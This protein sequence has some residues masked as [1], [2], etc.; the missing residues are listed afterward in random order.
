MKSLGAKDPCWCGSE[1]AFRDCHKLQPAHEANTINA[2]AGV[3]RKMQRWKKCYHWGAPQECARKIIRAHTIQRK[4][5]LRHIL[6]SSQHCLTF[7]EPNNDQS[8]L[9]IPK[10]VGWRNATAFFGFCEDHDRLFSEIEDGNFNVCSRNLLLAAYR[11]VSFEFHQKDALIDAFEHF[12]TDHPELKGNAQFEAMLD[13][14]REGLRNASK[15]SAQLASDLQNGRSSL[16]HAIIEINGQAEFLASGTPSPGKIDSG[17]RIALLGTKLPLDGFLFVSV[18]EQREGY[19]WCFSY[20]EADEI[21]EAYVRLIIDNE[22]NVNWTILPH[23]ICQYC[24]HTF[25]HGVGGKR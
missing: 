8:N 14:Q 13:V 3:T 22:T 1:K 11:V 17:P 9:P 21:A 25:F 4:G 23:L 6:D 2:Q 7:K 20:P 16:Q 10:E 5:I 15:F 12:F 19:V 18:H 24:E